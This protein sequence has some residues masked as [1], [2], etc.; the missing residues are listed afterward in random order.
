M[1]RVDLVFHA[2]GSEKKRSFLCPGLL[3]KCGWNGNFSEIWQPLVKILVVLC[4]SRT[5]G[6]PAGLHHVTG[7]R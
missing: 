6:L 5:A 1:H 3:L 2:K 4:M 7:L